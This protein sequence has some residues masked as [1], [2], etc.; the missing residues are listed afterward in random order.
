M[1]MPVYPRRVGKSSECRCLKMCVRKVQG[2]SSC[3]GGTDFSFIDYK[4]IYQLNPTIKNV[5]KQNVRQVRTRNWMSMPKED[6]KDP[7]HPK[8]TKHRKDPNFPLVFRNSLRPN[9]FLICG[10]TKGSKPHLRS[11]SYLTQQFVSKHTKNNPAKK[12]HK[13]H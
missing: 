12:T 2:R 7:K 8:D 9:C 3:I 11:L 4:P 10:K 1:C 5:Y 6:P 13:N